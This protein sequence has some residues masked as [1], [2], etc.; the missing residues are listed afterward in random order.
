MDEKD[1][2]Q[3]E[4]AVRDA[5]FEVS[6]R[7]GLI[8]G[9][10]PSIKIETPDLEGGT[11]EAVASNSNGAAI[12]VYLHHAANEKRW[13]V[14]SASLEGPEASIRNLRTPKAGATLATHIECLRA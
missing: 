9:G 11:A 4:T 7:E 13:T 1:N 14:L 10:F 3:I 2:G 6:E 8:R 12:R 5:V